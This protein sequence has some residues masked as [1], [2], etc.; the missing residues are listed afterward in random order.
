MDEEFV[1][2]TC[3]VMAWCF[4]G[5]ANPYADAVL[6]RLRDRYRLSRSIPRR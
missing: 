3:V 4:Q 5:A 6:E 1:V 2:V